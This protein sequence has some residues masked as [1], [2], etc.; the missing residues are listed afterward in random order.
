MWVTDVSE[1]GVS[2]VVIY[3]ANDFRDVERLR[4]RSVDNP[5]PAWDFAEGMKP[6]SAPETGL[7][8][9]MEAAQKR[10][11]HLLQRIED[12]EAR[13]DSLEQPEPSRRKAAPARKA[14]A[15]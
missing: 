7:G 13:L 3:D 15:A 6:A 11:A 9:Q 14:K 5:W 2:G 8:A 10:T 1:G 12:V 4:I